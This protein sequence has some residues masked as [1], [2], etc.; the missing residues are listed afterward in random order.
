MPD[1]PDL[2]VP[3]PIG[4]LPLWLAA[5][6]VDDGDTYWRES[7]PAILRIYRVDYS[8]YWNL[9]VAEHRAFLRDAGLTDEAT[10]GA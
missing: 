8:D 9:T 4:D 2:A 7:M 10:D 6:Y 5:Q 3:V 1:P